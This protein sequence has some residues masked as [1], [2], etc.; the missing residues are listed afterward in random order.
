MRQLQH[1]LPLVSVVIPTRDR[2]TL[3]LHTL[4]TVRR[5]EGARLE[6]IVVDDGSVD[7][8]PGALAGVDDSRLR[9]LRRSGAGGVA[10]ARNLGIAASTGEWVAFLDDDDVWVPDKLRKQLAAVA[11]TDA[12]LCY[13]G[14][15]YIDGAGRPLRIRRTPDPAELPGGIL[16][17]NLIG[18]PSTVIVRADELRRTGGFDEQL[19][20]L[21]DWDMWIR[22]LERGSAVVCDEI[23]AGY[24]VHGANMHNRELAGIRSERIYLRRKHRARSK[25]L[26]EPVAGPEFSMWLVVRYRASGRRIDAAREYLSLALRQRRLRHL[27]RATAML[28]RRRIAPTQ[29]PVEIADPALGWLDVAPSSTSALDGVAVAAPRVSVIVTARNEERRLPLLLEMLRRQTLPRDEFELIVVDDGSTD[30]TA[31]LAAAESGAVVVRALNHVGLAA[32]RNLGVRAARAPIL[33]FTDADCLPS[34]DW[35]ELGV[36][37]FAAE[38]ID[39]LAGGITIV[40]ERTTGSALVDAAWHLDQERY[41]ERGFAAGANLWLQRRLVEELRGFDE[42][43]GPYG[44]EEEFCQRA[45]RNGARIVYA[46]EVQVDHPARDRARDLSRKAF[47]LGFGLAAHRRL[48]DGTLG[49]VRRLFAD[50]REFLPQRRIHGLERL[51]RRGVYPTPLLRARMYVAQQMCLVLPKVIGDLAGELRLAVRPRSAMSASS[52][53]AVAI[54]A[55]TAPVDHER[56]L[57][58][59]SRS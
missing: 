45:T 19:N 11:G 52:P 3:L 32:G 21:A 15:V 34:P 6:I 51:R 12:V 56:D 36:S 42:R 40:I 39:I 59:S 55:A 16:R 17:T 41:V 25:Q 13:T 53:G 33:A 23:L 35:L 2:A 8:T 4:E 27:A 37:R 1:T 49:G 20:A 14:V 43:L 10:A 44:E 46:P 57:S 48:N 30:A 54:V 24:R 22:L 7:D 28:V 5:Q 58:A 50:P 9:V 38:P 29:Q 31:T 47:L 26:R 18:G